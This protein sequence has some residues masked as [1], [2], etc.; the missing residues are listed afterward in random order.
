MNPSGSMIAAHASK[1]DSFNYDENVYIFIVRA[2][3]GRYHTDVHKIK[4]A[5]KGEGEFTVSS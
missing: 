1:W 5:T 4:H 3:D 2:E